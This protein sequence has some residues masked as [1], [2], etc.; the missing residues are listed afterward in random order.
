MKTGFEIESIDPSKRIKRTW[1][2]TFFV[3]GILMVL[4]YVITMI[5][6]TEY[7]SFSEEYKGVK[8][9][10]VIEKTDHADE[11]AQRAFLE[12]K[13]IYE[14]YTAQYAVIPLEADQDELYYADS[15]TLALVRKL[16][17][18][19]EYS[20]GLYDYTLGNLALLYDEHDQPTEEEIDDTIE[21]TGFYNVEFTEDGI[22]LYNGVKL[23]LKPVAV[24]FAMDSVV[25]FLKNMHEKQ[26][27]YIQV[28]RNLSIIGKRN[29]STQWMDTINLPAE[30]KVIYLGKG[31]I[32]RGRLNELSSITGR[33]EHSAFQWG[34]VVSE[35]ALQAKTAMM[36]LNVLEREKAIEY[37]EKWSLICGFRYDDEMEY[38][39]GF[40]GLFFNGNKVME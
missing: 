35:S 8:I 27:G 6:N 26:T 3:I 10:L 12:F 9:R 36:A 2:F 32:W 4:L 18:I 23:Y 15:E 39:N 33:F 1:I 38:F 24:P 11:Y 17:M 22:K 30:E 21:K 16:S 7:V 19:A 40:E 37:I 14:K 31:A 5:Y 28:G 20:G 34:I 13:R 29:S 25:A